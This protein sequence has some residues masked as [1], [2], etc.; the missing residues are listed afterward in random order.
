M[1]CTAADTCL[2][3]QLNNAENVI[4]DATAVLAA[5]QLGAV[6]DKKQER[7]LQQKALYR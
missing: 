1:P 3:L 7:E 6:K 2:V 4:A 5:L